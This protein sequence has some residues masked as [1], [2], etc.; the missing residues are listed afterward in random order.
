VR[1]HAERQAIVRALSHA[2]GKITEAAELLGVS[3]PTM[4]DFIRKFSLKV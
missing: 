3:R 2:N 1:E 4:Y